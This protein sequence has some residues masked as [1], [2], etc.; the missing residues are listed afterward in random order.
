MIEGQ[1]TEGTLRLG[2]KPNE[3]LDQPG[4]RGRLVFSRWRARGRVARQISRISPARW[5][6]RAYRR[7]RDPAP[8]GHLP[9][10]TRFRQDTDNPIT[11]ATQ[12]R[13]WKDT[14]FCLDVDIWTNVCM[15]P[16][17]RS[18]SVPRCPAST[19][20][21]VRACANFP[22][23]YVL[24]VH[25]LWPNAFHDAGQLCASSHRRSN[26]RASFSLRDLEGWS[27]GVSKIVSHVNCL[28]MGRSELIRGGKLR[29]TGVNGGTFRSTAS[30]TKIFEVTGCLTPT[31][32]VFGKAGRTLQ[33]YVMMAQPICCI[34]WS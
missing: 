33:Q 17:S 29:T 34:L 22:S 7:F 16:R 4:W 11:D 5:S 13:L 9:C 24:Y 2:E 20:D 31:R 3:T 28:T 23:L 27:D 19:V 12:Q 21:S 8:P 30:D 14:A 32:I 6:D 10:W 1:L 18:P 15:Q 25:T 26:A